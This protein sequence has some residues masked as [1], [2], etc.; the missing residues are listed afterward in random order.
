MLPNEVN[1]FEIDDDFK[2]KEKTESLYKCGIYAIINIE[3]TKT[4]IG[5]TTQYFIDRLN[6]HLYELKNNKHH[7]AYLQNSVNKY[8]ISKFMILILEEIE[9]V[10]DCNVFLK[11]EKYYIDL[12]NSYVPNGYNITKVHGDINKDKNELDNRIE[13]IEKRKVNRQKVQQNKEKS[14]MQCYNCVNYCLD[15]NECYVGHAVEYNILRCAKNNFDCSDY[16]ENAE[17]DIFDMLPIDE[18]TELY[19]NGIDIC[20]YEDKLIGGDLDA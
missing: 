1:S 19:L 6:L 7:N 18:I 12:F 8:G 13:K 4:Y 20:E 2:I 5:S 17:I 3:D 11:R 16:F 10:T 9:D 15:T 14:I